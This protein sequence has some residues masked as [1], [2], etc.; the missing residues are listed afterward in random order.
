MLENVI[1]FD[2]S[3]GCEATAARKILFFHPPLTPLREQVNASQP[4]ARRSLA[5]RDR[6]LR[7]YCLP[8]CVHR[9]PARDHCLPMPEC[10]LPC[11]Y[12]HGTYL[13]M[14]TLHIR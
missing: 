6:M 2:P 11:S 9:L 4:L 10:R 8:A 13:S 3:L 14:P 5:A 1:I 7:L 12:L